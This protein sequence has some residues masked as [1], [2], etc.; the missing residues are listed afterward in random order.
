MTES[1]D[2]PPAG[3]GPSWRP[4]RDREGNLASIVVGG[5]LL[6]LGVWYLLDHTFDVAMPRIDWGDLW[7]VFL[8]VIGGVVIFQSTRRRA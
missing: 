1:S 2:I 4:P 7:P 5:V 3:A 6:A 8:I